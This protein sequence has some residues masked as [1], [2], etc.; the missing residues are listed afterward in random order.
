MPKE[1][2]PEDPMELKAV[3]VPDC[4]T[5]QV[6]DDIVLEYLFMGWSD[7]QILR[8]FRSPF[9]GATH[10]ILQSKG[11]SFVEERVHH[12][13]GQWQRGWIRGGETNA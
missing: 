7:R 9:F 8:L 2:D 3:P 4:D 13:A 11:P 12:L 10:Q 6:M 5:E 1:F